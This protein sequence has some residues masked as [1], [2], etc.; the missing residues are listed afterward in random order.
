MLFSPNSI[1][2]PTA[3]RIGKPEIGT[4]LLINK[5]IEFTRVLLKVQPHFAYVDFRNSR[6]TATEQESPE[7]HSVIHTDNGKIQITAH[8]RVQ[9]C[10]W[11]QLRMLSHSNMTDREIERF[12]VSIKGYITHIYAYILVGVFSHNYSYRIPSTFLTSGSIPRLNKSWMISHSWNT[13]SNYTMNIIIHHSCIRYSLPN[14]KTAN[15][16]LAQKA[17]LYEQ[18]CR[19][20]FQNMPPHISQMCA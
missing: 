3:L 8:A 1:I 12:T 11:E 14:T 15:T 18:V 4:V 6:S 17:F 16:K 5:I 13:T 9:D 19:P 10:E 2:A 20:I 7:G